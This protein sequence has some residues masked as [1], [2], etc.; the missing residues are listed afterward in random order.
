M[1]S[2]LLIN[3]SL[4]ISGYNCLL[5][6]E[7]YR[8]TCQSCKTTPLP[9]VHARCTKK[10]PPLYIS[11]TQHVFRPIRR[12][13]L[14]CLISLV[15]ASQLV[16]LSLQSSHLTPTTVQ[17]I[18]RLHVSLRGKNNPIWEPSIHKKGK[19]TTLLYKISMYIDTFMWRLNKNRKE[20]TYTHKF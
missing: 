12:H 11:H 6:C 3:S 15:G 19:I 7:K 18:V 5:E 2:Y 10:F 1:F 14:V 8:K 17:Y 20:C 13:P 4:P 9:S 16:G